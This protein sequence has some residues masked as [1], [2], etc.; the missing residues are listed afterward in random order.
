MDYVQELI[1]KKEKE[2]M[3]NEELEKLNLIKEI[4]KNEDCF[5]NL[6]LE[7]SIGILEFLGV[8]EEEMLD[9]YT[10][11]T[12]PYEF[13]KRVPKERVFIDEEIDELFSE[14]RV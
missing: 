12:S 2:I 9:F 3:N 13:E 8:S 10:K 11:L 4:T 14:R 6:D 1:L 5:F 7:T